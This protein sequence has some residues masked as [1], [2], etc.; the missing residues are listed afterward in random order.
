LLIPLQS[1][2][3][4]DFVIVEFVHLFAPLRDRILSKFVQVILQ[5]PVRV[6]EP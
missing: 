1:K 3:A 6:K 2:Q 5:L 4:R